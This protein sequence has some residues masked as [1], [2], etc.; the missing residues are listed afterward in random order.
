LPDSIPNSPTARAEELA[1]QLYETGNYVESCKL[2]KKMTK[3]E[4]ERF[5]SIMHQ[6]RNDTRNELS[7]T[8]Y[9]A[10]AKRLYF[11]EKIEVLMNEVGME[12]TPKD[13][14]ILYDRAQQSVIDTLS[15][16]RER[17]TTVNNSLDL[18]KKAMHDVLN[19]SLV[20][21]KENIID[22]NPV[23]GTEAPEADKKNGRRVMDAE[24][25]GDPRRDI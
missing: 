8:E 3:V 17:K 21:P 19:D 13:V 16:F 6:L 10:I 4:R 5:D 15:R 2:L 11:C 23:T 12:K 9:F 18:L 20:I 14:L 7:E 25:E 22:V 1:I 24:A